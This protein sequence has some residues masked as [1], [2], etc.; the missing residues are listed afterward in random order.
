MYVAVGLPSGSGWTHLN[1]KAAYFFSY[2]Q[3]SHHLSRTQ[4]SSVAAGSFA[5]LNSS[6]TYMQMECKMIIYSRGNM[7]IKG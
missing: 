2:H 1:T 4:P 3:G 7:Y 5:S 6:L